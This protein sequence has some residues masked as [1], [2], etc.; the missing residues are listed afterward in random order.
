MDYKNFLGTRQKIK[1]IDFPRFFTPSL[2]GGVEENW[3]PFRVLGQ[4]QF[5]DN[6]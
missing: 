4:N 6:Q 3:T 2:K 1:K 5:S